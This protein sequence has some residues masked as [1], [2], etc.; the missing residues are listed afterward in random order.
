VTKGT[1]P[2]SCPTLDERVFALRWLLREAVAALAL[3]PARK[4]RIA[5]LSWFMAAARSPRKP[6]PW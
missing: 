3:I 5:H 1:D 4:E 6:P 2:T